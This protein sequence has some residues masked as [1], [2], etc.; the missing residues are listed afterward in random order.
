LSHQRVAV[1]L[2]LRLL[3]AHLRP[4]FIVRQDSKTIVAVDP[5]CSFA[6]VCACL[7]DELSDEECNQ[8]R[9]AY[10]RP[11]R[12]QHLADELFERPI[13]LY[14]P[15]VLRLH[16]EG[17]LQGGEELERRRA[18]GE[19]EDEIEM[20]LAEYETDLEAG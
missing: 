1:Y 12:G 15:P 13:H 18:A 10:G 6:E 7:A 3:P 19:L 4:C 11:P 8:I 16:G 14:V 20:L 9:V 2:T 5:R 17:P